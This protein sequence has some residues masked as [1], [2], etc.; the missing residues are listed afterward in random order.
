V[1]R[2]TRNGCYVPHINLCCMVILAIRTP[3]VA[4]GRTFRGDGEPGFVGDGSPSAFLDGVQRRPRGG[5]VMDPIVKPVICAVLI[6]LSAIGCGSSNPDG[7]CL[8][9][10]READP[11]ALPPYGATSLD[12]AIRKCRTLQ[13]WRM[14]WEAVPGAHVG[15]SD[16]VAF[17][18]ERCQ[19]ADLQATPLCA[20]VRQSGDDPT[21]STGTVDPAPM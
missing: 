4:F 21:R 10:F 3:S 18:E 13:S 15:R 14:A 19:D 16:P 17:L 5:R 9:A 11:R 12:D 7:D 6:A 1:I 20:A 2:G 8:R